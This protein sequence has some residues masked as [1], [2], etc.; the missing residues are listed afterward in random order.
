M[1]GDSLDG[2]PRHATEP[3]LSLAVIRIATPPTRRTPWNPRPP[4]VIG[5]PTFIALLR[6]INVGGHNQ[7]PMGELR[8]LCEGLGWADVQTYIQSG[9]VVFRADA[10]APALEDALGR[11][12]ERGF[13]LSI[14]VLVRSAAEWAE[15]LRGNP[16]PDA[17]DA[18]PNLVMLALSKNPPAHTAAD[19]LGRRG[20]R[21]ERVALVG[22]AL[23][24]HF[25][26]GAGRSKLSPAALDRLA[27]SPVTT[28]NWR[29]VLKLAEL[30][31]AVDLA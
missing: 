13:G 15:Y 30:A 12:I 22:D 23:W 8:S 18:E 17:S 1:P 16:F 3:A 7:I 6:G 4:I 9:N 28:R 10:A 25:A 26:G 19:E 5:M 27:G 21:G 2:C 20:D 24:I 29:T 31:G 11:A 14:P